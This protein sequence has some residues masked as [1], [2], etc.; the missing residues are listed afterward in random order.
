M[1]LPI[2]DKPTDIL[3][4]SVA[5]DPNLPA[6]AYLAMSINR[7]G[8]LHLEAVQYTQDN[9]IASATVHCQHSCLAQTDLTELVSVAEYSFFGHLDA[10]SYK[11]RKPSQAFQLGK[12]RL[13]SG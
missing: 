1:P 6:G 7:L 10:H 11:L 5:R 12:D 2:V 3:A 8:Q 9:S 13:L 4:V